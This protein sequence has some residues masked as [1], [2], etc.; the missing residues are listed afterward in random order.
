M[1]KFFCG[2]SI[3]VLAIGVAIGTIDPQ[4]VPIVTGTLVAVLGVKESDKQ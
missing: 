4:H 1:M 2:F 3:L